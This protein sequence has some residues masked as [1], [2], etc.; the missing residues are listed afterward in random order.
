M[1]QLL[2]ALL[3]GAVL[4]IAGAVA[5]WWV[6]RAPLVAADARAREATERLLAAH[7]DGWIIPESESGALPPVLVERLPDPVLEYVEQFDPAGQA[8][9]EAKARSLIEH[10]M[11]PE[12][13]VLELERFRFAR[14]ESPA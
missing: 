2:G 12:F 10:G 8:V 9:Y 1:A 5:A 4:T 11:K 7:R 13:V 6:L 3:A 14:Q